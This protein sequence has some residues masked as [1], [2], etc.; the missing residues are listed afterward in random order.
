MYAD[1]LQDRH[2]DRCKGTRMCVLVWHSTSQLYARCRL[3]VRR[4]TSMMHGHGHCKSITTPY[5]RQ[6]S[7]PLRPT[8]APWRGVT[9]SSSTKLST[10]HVSSHTVMS[11]RA[12]SQQ[13]SVTHVSHH[14]HLNRHQRRKRSGSRKSVRRFRRRHHVNVRELTN[15]R[16]QRPWLVRSSLG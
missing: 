8:C 12:H 7:R 2:L 14:H 1:I 3:T 5:M 16:H 11:T 9:S 13:Y 4:A 10:A 6:R 15:Q